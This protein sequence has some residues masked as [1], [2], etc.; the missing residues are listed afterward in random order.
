MNSDKKRVLLVTFFILLLAVS[1]VAFAS[2]E[3]TCSN[4]ETV[5]NGNFCSNCGEKKLLDDSAVSDGA[6]KLFIKIDFE[7]NLFFSTYDVE[8][9]L[10]GRMIGEMPHGKSFE[11]VLNVQ[12]GDYKFSFYE[13]GDRSVK[14][15]VSVM[16]STDTKFSCMIHAKKDRI[17]I[18]GV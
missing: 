4:C 5:N 16:V 7:E 17:K 3:W 1:L 15:E 10:N 11:K 8:V 9:Y 13:K 2:A 14:G 6:L 12:P 18:D